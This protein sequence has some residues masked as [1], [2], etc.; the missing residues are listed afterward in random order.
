MPPQLEGS[1]IQVIVLADQFVIEGH[2]ISYLV[3]C[4]VGRV[5]FYK[6]PTLPTPQNRTRPTAKRYSF[7]LE[8]QPRRSQ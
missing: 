3:I 2:V 1:S 5:L 8:Q 6:D 4:C 7:G